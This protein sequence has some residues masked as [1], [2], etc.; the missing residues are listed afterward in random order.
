PVYIGWA[1]V[2]RSALVRIPRVVKGKGNAVRMELRCPDPSANPYL[3]F[4]AMLHAGLEGIDQNLQH[5]A[6]LNNINVYELSEEERQH[7]GIR[8]L[9]ASLSEALRE[10]QGDPLMHTV[11]N[12]SL[13]DKFVVSRKVEIEAYRLHV[14]DWEISRYLETL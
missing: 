11:L 14:S 1:Q 6:S 5:P 7:L 3:A 4:N 2:N 10:F 12:D 13:Y 8:T 9:P